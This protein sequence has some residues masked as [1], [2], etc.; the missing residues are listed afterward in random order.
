MSSLTVHTPARAAAALTISA[1]AGSVSDAKSAAA[2]AAGAA[3]AFGGEPI[4]GAFSDMCTRGQEAMGVLQTTM[5]SLSR[6]VAAAARA[7]ARIIGTIL[8]YKQ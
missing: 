7:A 1:N 6:N 3:G 5:E 4:G 2:S 8:R